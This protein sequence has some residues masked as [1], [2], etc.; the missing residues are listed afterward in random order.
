MEKR[1][2]EYQIDRTVKEIPHVIYTINI[3]PNIHN[4]GNVLEASRE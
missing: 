3:K 2:T 4:N 1:H